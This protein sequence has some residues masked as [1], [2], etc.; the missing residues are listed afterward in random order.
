MEAVRAGTAA[1]PRSWPAVLAWTLF[2]VVLLVFAGYPWLDRLTRDAGRPDLAL[3]QPFAIAP[4]L[5]ALSAGAVGAVLAGRRPRH[6][7]GWL[8][9]TIGLT[10]STSGAAAGYLP[11]LVVRPG[12]LP[13]VH[14]V[15]RVYA[16]LVEAALAALGFVLLLTPTGSPPSPRWRGW[17]WGSARAMAVLLVAATLSP[18]S[19]DLPALVVDGPISVRPFGGALRVANLAAQALAILVILA[20]TASLVVRFR[21]T[22]GVER[23]QLRW[24][25][26][27]P[28]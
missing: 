25:A 26:L 27:P 24:V 12:A 17:A 8:L 19:L 2:A 14:V 7:V 20:G 18:G 28:P 21:R 3:L 6:P 13:G 15:A 11:Y 1:R 22:R 9:L 23:Q 4:T 5:A 16:P 10:M